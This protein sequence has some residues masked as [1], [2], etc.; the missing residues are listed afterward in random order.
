MCRKGGEDQSG[1][2]W[3]EGRGREAGVKLHMPHRLIS[4]RLVP[5]NLLP[6]PSATSPRLR[7]RKPRRMRATADM[8]ETPTGEAENHHALITRTNKRGGNANVAGTLTSS[9]FRLTLELN[10]TYTTKSNN[11]HSLKGKWRRRTP[12]PPQ[13]RSRRRTS[14]SC[15]RAAYQRRTWRRARSS[16]SF[17]GKYIPKSPTANQQQAL[18]T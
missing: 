10:V 6:L 11:P 9:L 7:P 17:G 18:T 12:P 4:S 3:E 13:T 5:P 8:T 14:T 16:R 1:R 2:T 15:S